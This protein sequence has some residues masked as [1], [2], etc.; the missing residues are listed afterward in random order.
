MDV[1][2]NTTEVGFENQPVLKADYTL[3][4]GYNHKYVNFL[5]GLSGIY[6]TVSGPKYPDKENIIQY[7]L[8]VT[9]LYKNIRPALSIKVPG[10]DNFG[11]L[12]YVLGLNFTYGFD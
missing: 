10:K 6:N 2:F 3:Q 9:F 8:L 1:W 4:I 12:N 7:G 11:R 5:F